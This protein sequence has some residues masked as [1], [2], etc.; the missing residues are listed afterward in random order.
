VE[1]NPIID[2]QNATSILAVDFICSALGSR[3][4]NE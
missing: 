2:V 4:W 1:V 3:I